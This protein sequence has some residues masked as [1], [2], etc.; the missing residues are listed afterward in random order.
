MFSLAKY[1]AN[2]K[3]SVDAYI[4]KTITT[5]NHSSWALVN[6]QGLKNFTYWLIK[7]PDI[8]SDE[9][10]LRIESAWMSGAITKNLKEMEEKEVHGDT[11]PITEKIQVVIDTLKEEM[12]N[13]D[14]KDTKPTTDLFWA[15]QDLK[16]LFCLSHKKR[17]SI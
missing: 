6:E 4:Y 7:N 9:L 10:R 2:L 3:Q 17:L 14:E 13:L 5:E 8:R 15:L 1:A 16:V 11:K 12:Q